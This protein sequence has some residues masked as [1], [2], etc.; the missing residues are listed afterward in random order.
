MI[1]LSSVNEDI[2]KI[3]V[4]MVAGSI[5]GAERE[6]KSKNAGFRTITLIT[7]G[8]TLYTLLSREIAGGKDF[9]VVGNI[10]VG[11][12]FLGAGAIFKEGTSVSGLTTAA[13][14]WISAAIGMAI[15]AGEYVFAGITLITVLIILLG[16][17]GIQGIIDSK[18]AEKY[19]KICI[20]NHNE[21][22][23]LILNLI[24]LCQLKSQQV[25]MRK[26]DN[27]FYYTFKISG[28]LRKHEKLL[29]L[30]SS[31]NEILSFEV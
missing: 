28:A 19:Y 30:L 27:R 10:V 16:F 22:D 26:V 25:N 1:P 2:V 7:I 12:G 23:T 4:S 15:G 18:N 3:F 21:C 8:A 31:S 5:I 17:S 6:Y 11:V 24:K 14:I 13:T 9:H 20:H 29:T